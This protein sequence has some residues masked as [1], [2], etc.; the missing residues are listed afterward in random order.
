MR[1]A[2]SAIK[3]G[4]DILQLRWKGR[5]VKGFFTLARGLR[6]VTR[7]FKVLFIIDD[8]PNLARAIKADGVHLGQKD[9]SI[10]DARSILGKRFI[11]GAS[12][13]NLFQARRAVS[14]G[15][16]Y[17]SIGPVFKTP[18]KAGRKAVGVKVISKLKK[19]IA[20]PVFAIGGINLNNIKNVIRNGADRIAVIRAIGKAKSPKR[21]A[22]VLKEKLIF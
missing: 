22:R 10:K 21:A 3:G 11:I 1:V 14:Y 20:L 12:T 13:S 2:T 4:V 5:E 16:D 6:K 9:L 17:I 15:A 8:D 18:I 7:R 19:E